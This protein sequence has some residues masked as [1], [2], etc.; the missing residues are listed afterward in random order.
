M[1]VV[2][3]GEENPDVIMLLHG[4]GLSWWNYRDEARLLEKNYHVVVPVLD[5]H[6]E[7]DAPFTTIEDNAR[8]IIGY[9]DERFHGSVLVMGGLSLGGQILV[10]AL[11]QRSTI[12]TYAIIES[13]LVVPMPL[14]SALIAPTFGAS[15][16]L[17]KKKWFAR[18]QFKSLKIQAKLFDDYYRDTCKI[19]KEDMVRFL[20]S[21]SSYEMKP[22]LASTIAKATILVG[23]KEQ[24]TMLRSAEILHDTIPGSTLKVLQGYSHGEFSLNHPEDYVELL[25]RMVS[26]PR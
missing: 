6:A 2:E 22:E 10:E 7:S 25:T 3:Y 16:G 13:A 23:G 5:G 15:Y 26:S 4:G 24:K 9:I 14:T 21:N 12:C 20:K 19:Q 8:E 17:I 1:R 11:S 18:L